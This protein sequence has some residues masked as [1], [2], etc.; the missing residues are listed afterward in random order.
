IDLA[1]E[2]LRYKTTK[3]ARDPKVSKR[4]YQLL[5]ALNSYPVNIKVRTTVATPIPPE[6]GHKSK[7]VTLG[8][9]RRLGNDYAE[10]G[11]RMAFHSLEDDLEGF[12]PGAQINIFSGKVR[13][14]EGKGLR[15]YQFDLIDI[16]SLTPRNKFFKPLSWKVRSGFERQLTKGQDQLVYHLTG[17]AGGTWEIIKNHQF[18]ALGLGRLEINDQ[19]KHTLGPGIGFNSGF[20]SH[21]KHTTAHL[22]FSGEQLVN[23]IYRLRVQY[24]QN[25]VISTNHSFKIF[26]KNQW[27]NNGTEF[28]DVNINYQYY[29]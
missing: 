6:N 14:E 12:L 21:F 28:S 7:R 11:L 3:K 8:G 4:S 23:D 17:G 10:I 9:G 19:L 22:E 24:T 16:F 2:Y 15:L 18:Y 20:L 26:A 13:V 29:F 1:Y 27:Q 25:F 5:Q